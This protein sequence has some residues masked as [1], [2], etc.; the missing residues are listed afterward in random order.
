M[1]AIPLQGGGRLLLTNVTG[2]VLADV[3]LPEGGYEL[4]LSREAAEQL[5]EALDGL[6]RPCYR[7]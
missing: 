5:L 3:R 6:L 1:R 2:G 7:R 4:V